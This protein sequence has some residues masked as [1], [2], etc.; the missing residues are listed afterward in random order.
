MHVARHTPQSHHTPQIKLLSISR[1]VSLK[2]LHVKNDLSCFF[3]RLSPPLTSDASELYK[4]VPRV[5][6]RV[7]GRGSQPDLYDSRPLGGAGAARRWQ[8]I[9]HG[10]NPGTGGAHTPHPRLRQDCATIAS[11][12][13]QELGAPSAA[14]RWLLEVHAPLA[15]L[16]V[17]LD[18]QGAQLGLQIVRCVEVAPA[19]GPE[20]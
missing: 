6:Y 10:K 3:E 4:I 8:H 12:C 17:G 11:S 20:A 19:L 15:R 18:A 1:C 13:R 14:A 9:Q 16:V 7:Y 5:L 2:H